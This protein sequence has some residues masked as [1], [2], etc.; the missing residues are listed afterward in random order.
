MQL[1]YLSKHFQAISYLSKSY[2]HLNSPSQTKQECHRN[3]LRETMEHYS[4]FSMLV[5]HILNLTSHQLKTTLSV[6]FLQAYLIV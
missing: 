5:Q 3:H 4:L 6:N 1:S 2:Q